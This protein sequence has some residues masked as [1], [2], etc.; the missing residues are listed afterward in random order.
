[1]SDPSL[2]Q[3]DSF[4]R[5]T[6]GRW[7]WDEERQLR[8]RYTLFNVLELQRIAARCVGAN[9]CVS[10]TKLAEGSFN[11]TFRLMMDNGSAAIARLPHPIAGPKYYTTASEVATMDFARTVLQI[12]VP[13]VHSWNAHVDNPVGAEYII[14][15]E[16]AGTKLGDVWDKLPLEDRITIMKDLVLI[17]KK[18]LSVSFSSY[19]NLYYSSEPI[20]GSASAEITND[21]SLEVKSD[22]KKRFSIGPV[23]DRNF[24]SKERSVMNIDRGPW[25]LSRDYVAALAHQ[26]L[27]WVQQYAVPRSADD[28]PISAAQNTPGAH[29]SLL[30]KYLQV[31]PYLLPTDLDI[32]TPTIWHT[33]LHSGNL[34][35]DK[36][37][38]TS[39]IDWQGSWAGPLLLQGRHPR[40]VDHHGDIILKPPAN[41]KQLEPNKQTQL[42]KQIASSIILYLYEQQTAKVNP[43]LDQVLRFKLGQ[44]RCDPISFASN[45]WDDDILP[46][47]ESLINLEKHWHELG[48]DFACPIHFTE[49]ELQEHAKDGEGWNEVQDFWRTVEGIVTRDGWT[50][51]D[52]YDDAVALFSEL[53]EIGLKD[54]VGKDR[55]DFEAQ[56]QWVEKSTSQKNK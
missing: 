30:Q 11:K 44:V 49:E 43:R 53:R 5:Y 21:T 23:V 6:S 4:F 36:G 28:L 22:V 27:N 47:R 32:V 15:E 55:K 33:D 45:T 48:F 19:G 35:V 38:I 3:H 52:L 46:L 54:M 10:M 8:D 29:I 40:L 31:A 24:W 20:P 26:E 41:F 13:Q 1:M 7:L 12:P 50:P 2:D 9:K 25:K 56:T 17:E 16:A 51:H 42:R 14:M 18:L 39:V 34:F 37:H